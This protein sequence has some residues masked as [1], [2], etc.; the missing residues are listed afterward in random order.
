MKKPCIECPFNKNSLKGYLGGFTVNE[1]LEVANSE[2]SFL[3]HL[4]REN[5][6]KSE[7]V[8]RLLYSTKTCK[9]FRNEILE[10]QRLEVKSLGTENILG[11]DF[12]K[13]HESN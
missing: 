9:S 10:N 8:G 3:C 2:Q 7:C 1:T 5:N 11:F 6:T 12:K 4:T 13:Y